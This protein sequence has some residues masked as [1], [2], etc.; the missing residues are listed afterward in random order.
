VTKQTFLFFKRFFTALGL[1]K[2]QIC[3]IIGLGD[4]ADT[5]QL[6]ALISAVGSFIPV[7]KNI[8]GDFQ[9][10]NTDLSANLKGRTSL[11][12]LL[13]PIARYV[14]NKDILP[15]IKENMD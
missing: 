4:P 13:F 9:N 1:K 3:G 7:Q 14:L 11:F 10:K 8:R 12:A 15:I 2:F 5:G 6:I